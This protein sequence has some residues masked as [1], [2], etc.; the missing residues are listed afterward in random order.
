MFW[1]RKRQNVKPTRW[2][3]SP[4]LIGILRFRPLVRMVTLSALRRAARREIDAGV[5]AGGPPGARERAPQPVRGPRQFAGVRGDRLRLGERCGRV[6]K[7]SAQVLD[8]TEVVPDSID[9]AVDA[10]AAC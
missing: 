3:G 6:G 7:V 1:Y 4:W 10:A 9:R 2:S 5:R 8:D